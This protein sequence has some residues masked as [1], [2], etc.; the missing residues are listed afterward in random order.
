MIQNVDVFDSDAVILDLEDSVVEYEKDAARILVDEFL[1]HVQPQNVD[2]F[3]RINDPSSP[4]F[5]DDVTQLSAT[6]ICGFVL[7]K[8]S[9]STIKQLMQY[10]DKPLIPIIESPRGVL[11]SK[12]MAQHPQ[13]QG[14]LLGAED[15]SKEMNIQRT[16]D[17][18]EIEYVRQ[19]LA[20]VCRAYDIEAIDTPWIDKE[21]VIGLEADTE[22]AKQFG[23]TGKAAIHPNHIDCINT[24]FTPS[25]AAINEAMRIVKKAEETKKGAFSL[26]GKMVDRPIIEKAKKLLQLAH[27]YK[28]I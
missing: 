26:D 24:I 14:L 11:E 27:E 8:A 16:P 5:I 3:V 17:G 19:Y 28:I 15:F 10:T 13:V 2:V 6:K 4:H 9:L 20:I 1:R 18:L 22:T 21:D 25:Q 23:C 7:P 12:E